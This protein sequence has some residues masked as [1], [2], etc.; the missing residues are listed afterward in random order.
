MIPVRIVDFSALTAG[1]F[2]QAAQILVDAF[3]TMAPQSWPTLDDAR[4]EID[5]MC[6][7]GKIALAAL[8]GDSVA[9]II[10]GQ[11]D[12]ALV[13]ELHPL[14]V[15]PAAQRRGIGAALVRA[16]ESRVR[17]AGAVTLRLGTDDEMG[18]TSLGG[19]DV[20]PDPLHHLQTLTDV[21]GHP[22]VFYRKLGYAIVGLIPDA[23]GFGKPD[24]IMAKRL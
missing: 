17:A 15:A 7:A 23:N 2:T 3:V 24:I 16:L 20:Y 11:P 6:A 13:W 22:F 4:A 10:G 19:V 21:A 5:G 1:Q 9:G 18:L 14:A 8:E 12:Y